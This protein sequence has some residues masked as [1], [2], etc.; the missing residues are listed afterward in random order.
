MKCFGWVNALISRLL[1]FIYNRRHSAFTAAKSCITSPVICKPSHQISR[2]IRMTPRLP[3]TNR[4]VSISQAFLKSLAPVA[5]QPDAQMALQSGTGLCSNVHCIKVVLERLLDWMCIRFGSRK[6]ANA[7]MIK[8][9]ERNS[10][11]CPQ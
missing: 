3:S 11:T 2:P 9:F 6:S 5:L 1:S 8:V 7:L 4:R 10:Q